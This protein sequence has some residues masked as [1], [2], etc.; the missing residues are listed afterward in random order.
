[1]SSSGLFIP[2][3][4]FAN[5]IYPFTASTLTE[6]VAASLIL[7]LSGV[8]ALMDKQ[9]LAG[10]RSLA[11]TRQLLK[12]ASTE[13]QISEALTAY[14]QVRYGV[15]TAS[16]PLRDISSALE[17]HGCPAELVKRFEAL[18]QRLNAARFA[19]VDMQGEGTAELARQATELIKA[20]D[21]GGRA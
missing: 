1:M 7:G 3:S 13:E 16:L 17:K 4:F 2:N 6:Y 14:I 11:K 5:S 19:P 9:T 20:M 12:N 18:W 8:F 10:R 21:K 15:H